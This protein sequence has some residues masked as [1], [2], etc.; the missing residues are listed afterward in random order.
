MKE[1]WHHGTV[2]FYMRQ[3]AT[4]TSQRNY[5]RYCINEWCWIPRVA[6][7][8][9]QQ[10]L[11]L[12]P[13]PQH[14]EAVIL[15]LL[16]LFQKLFKQKKKKTKFTRRIFM[17]C[18]SCGDE[19]RQQFKLQVNN[20]QISPTLVDQYGNFTKRHMISKQEKWEK[21]YFNFRNK[22]SFLLN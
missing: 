18:N 5:I 10:N 8:R 7:P 9:N 4:K 16:W 19:Q 14:F 1:Q 12:L 6:I 20:E 13:T 15:Q 2:I 22:L 11:H 3:N 21:R 17:Q